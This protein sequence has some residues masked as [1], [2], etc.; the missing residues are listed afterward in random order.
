MS[1][2]SSGNGDYTIWSRYQP[3]V[4]PSGLSTDGL[5]IFVDPH[6]LSTPFI[7]DF[8]GDGSD[9]ELVIAS[10]FYFEDERLVSM[11]IWNLIAVLRLPSS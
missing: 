3:G 7:T 4:R 11:N 2:K 5:T 8:N 10:N 9:E 1:N 6:I